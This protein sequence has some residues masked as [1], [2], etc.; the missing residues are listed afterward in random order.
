MN[1]ELAWT[2]RGSVQIILEAAA[3]AGMAK[4]AQCLGFDLT[5]ALACDLELAPDFFE[6][7]AATIIEAEAQAQD[8][9]LADGQRAKR[10]LHLLLEDLVAG[11]LGGGESGADPR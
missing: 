5:D 2:R 9:L 11:G 3:A 8:F 1:K 10:V 6:R 4:L 7:A